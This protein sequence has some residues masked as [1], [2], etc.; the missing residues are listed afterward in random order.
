MYSLDNPS[1][2]WPEFDYTLAPG[3]DD[4]EA[5]YKPARQFTGHP[6]LDGMLIVWHGAVTPAGPPS[7]KDLADKIW[8]PWSTSLLLVECRGSGQACP[9]RR[10]LPG[11]DHAARAAA[12]LPGRSADGQPVDGGTGGDDAAGVGS[13]GDDPAHPAGKAGGATGRRFSR[14]WSGCRWRR[15]RGRSGGERCGRCCFRWRAPA[16]RG[17]AAGVK[18]PA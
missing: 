12:V 15:S 17:R 7:W 8:H 11:R 2:C 4:A 9:Q 13:A 18:V 3:D 5:P 14:W 1:A 10:G 6:T 16:R